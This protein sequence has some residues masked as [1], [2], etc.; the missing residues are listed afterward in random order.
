MNFISEFKEGVEGGVKNWALA[1]V[2]EARPVPVRPRETCHIT[3]WSLLHHIDL[4]LIASAPSSFSINHS[5]LI[6]SASIILATALENK[7][8]HSHI[9]LPW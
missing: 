8:L 2:L 4:I 5:Y 1:S 6:P 7:V 9:Y 3:S